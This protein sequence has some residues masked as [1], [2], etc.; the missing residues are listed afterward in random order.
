MAAHAQFYDLDMLM[1]PPRAAPLTAMDHVCDYLMMC[2]CVMLVLTLVASQMAPMFARAQS[3]PAHDR[4]RP[5][6]LPFEQV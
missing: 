6:G 4:V 2:D 1:S 5:F 3:G